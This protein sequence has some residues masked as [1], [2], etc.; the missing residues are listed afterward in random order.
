MGAPKFHFAARILYIAVA[1]ART[2]IA[3]LAYYAVAQVAIVC[4]VAKAHQYAVLYFAACN[5]IVA[6]ACGPVNFCTHFHHGI[7]AQCKW[8]T[9]H[10]AFHYH[11][12][13]ANI[14]GARSCI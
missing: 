12:I 5:T 4:L 14:N 11:C 10:A 6:N 8:A 1:G 7:V 2:K 3:P 9:Y 13:F